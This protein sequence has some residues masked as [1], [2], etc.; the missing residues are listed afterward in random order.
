MFFKVK[1]ANTKRRSVDF[2]DRARKQILRKQDLQ[3]QTGILLLVDDERFQITSQ[4]ASKHY[5]I[6]FA[7][8][9][10]WH[11]TVDFVTTKPRMN[12]MACNISVCSHL[13]NNLSLEVPYLFTFVHA[14]D[15]RLLRPRLSKGPTK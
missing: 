13:V 8:F 7:S 4:N 6:I 14:T 3:P 5:N 11:C 10:G 1:K 15:M 12:V 9:V 2:A